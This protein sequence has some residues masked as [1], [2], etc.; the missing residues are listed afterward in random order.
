MKRKSAILF[1]IYLGSF[2]VTPAFSEDVSM[3]EQEEPKEFSI[4]EEKLEKIQNEMQWLMS[5]PEVTIATKHETKLNRAPSI[6]TVI[7]DEEIKNLGY[8]T[9][10]EILRTV[11]GFEI[12]KTADLGTVVP[13]VRGLEAENKVRVMLNGHLINNPLRGSAFDNFDDYPVEN[14]KRIEIIRGP[15]SALYGENAF[16][17]VI[18]IITYDT[19]DI[20]GV[21]VSSGYGS[22][23]TYEE[24]VVF[25]KK[26][27]K[28][29]ISGMAHYR[30]T[31]GFNGTVESD[32]QTILD[33]TLSPFDFP[34]ASQAP[35]KVE[36]W[37]QEY[38][39]NLK[40]A[41]DDLYFQGWYEDKNRGPFIGP[42]YALNDETNIGGSYVFGE[43]GYKKTFEEMFTLKPRVYY[44]QFDTDNA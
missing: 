28:V 8:R 39:V 30:Q 37:R 29:N 1:L 23:D 27:G 15:G 32:A 43:V 14:I 10:V 34:M 33:S 41:Y 26:Y 19:E 24:N 3:P 44:D 5:E 40:V 2:N 38:D 4:S 17:A 6:V 18:N 22:F 16:L 35:G 11:P 25:G 20:D 21:K 13:A 31:S 12:L 9:F 7:T 36:D 42:H